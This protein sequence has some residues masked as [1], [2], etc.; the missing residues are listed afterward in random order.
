MSFALLFL[1]LP[2][3]VRAFVAPIATGH[4]SAKTN[5]DEARLNRWTSSRLYQQQQQPYYN[6]SDGQYYYY[7][8][9]DGQY[10]TENGQIWTS[11]EG[12]Y[13][14]QGQ[15]DPYQQ[16]NESINANEQQPSLITSN[17]AQEMSQLNFQ[18][19]I[20]YLSL[21]RQRAMEKRE[22]VNS[23]STDDDWMTLAQEKREAGDG[24]EA[25]L[26]DVGSEGDAAALGMGT[27]VTEGGIVVET[28][29]DDDEPKLL[30]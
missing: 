25:S 4:T 8:D 29:G 28:G 11:H 22:S 3:G 15:Y 5:I 14:H 19:G 6:E 17:F 7:N 23:G 13:Q 30:F 16:A 10:Y 20:D 18:G 27:F 9:V 1:L 26:N 21:A 24:W 2:T 12:E